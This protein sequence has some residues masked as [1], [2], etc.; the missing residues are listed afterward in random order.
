[1]AS[2]V[3]VGE[4][5]RD[6]RPLLFG[7]R[8]INGS[9]AA[10]GS[11]IVVISFIM[12][13]DD[14]QPLTGDERALLFMKCAGGKS[15]TCESLNGTWQ[16]ALL[17]FPNAVLGIALGFLVL[18]FGLGR[19]WGKQ[20]IKLDY[21]AVITAV[22]V[23]FQGVLFFLNRHGPRVFCPLCLVLMSLT[24]VA[25]FSIG[26]LQIRDQRFRPAD[27]VTDMFLTY[28]DFLFV[29]LPLFFLLTVFD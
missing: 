28:Y 11:G 23:A 12:L 10:A 16:S 6:R 22:A 14:L 4:R 29:L 17:G 15:F 1:M 2:P 25:C 20:I 24:L 9:L 19:T 3:P 13:I 27:R 18:G 26:R 8:W 7:D 21:L 5:V